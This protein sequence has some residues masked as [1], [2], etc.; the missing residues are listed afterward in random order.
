M[1]YAGVG[2]EEAWDMPSSMRHRILEKLGQKM[3]REV[4]IERQ[5]LLAMRKM[6]TGK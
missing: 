3:D 5:K 1:V 2:Y 4:D 6:W